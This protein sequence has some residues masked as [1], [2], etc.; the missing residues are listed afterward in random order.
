[1][2]FVQCLALA[3]C[4]I[5][6]RQADLTGAD[7]GHNLFQP[8][9]LSGIGCLIPQHPHMV[10][11]TPAIGIVSPFTQKVEHGIRYL[12]DF[13]ADDYENA[14]VKLVLNWWEDAIWNKDSC[15]E[16]LLNARASDLRTAI[17][18][19]DLKHMYLRQI[20]FFIRS[21]VSDVPSAVNQYK[22]E[23]WASITSKEE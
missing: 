23:R 12:R 21:V 3:H 13:A 8:R 11:Q 2:V 16:T 20:E 9:H 14:F 5:K 17:S 7:D 4:L 18:K 1:M 6:K 22:L 15:S 10:G 19:E